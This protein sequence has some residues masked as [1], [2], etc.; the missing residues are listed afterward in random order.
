M[1][2]ITAYVNTTR[3]HWLVEELQAL[4]VEE[5]EVTEYFK[6]RSQISRFELSC[7]DNLV[8]KVRAIVHRIGTCGQA[9]DHAVFVYTLEK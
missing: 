3:V 5:I 8:E 7:E 9:A 2:K 1:K 4:G 6:P